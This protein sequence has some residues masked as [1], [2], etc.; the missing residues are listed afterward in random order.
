MG[1]MNKRLDREW[2]SKRNA[3]DIKKVEEKVDEIEERLV[4]KAGKGEEAMYEKLRVREAKR[5]NVVMH[6]MLE[7]NKEKS[8]EKRI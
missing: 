5:L 1:E 8:E 3:D 4:S 6:R 7:P 2:R